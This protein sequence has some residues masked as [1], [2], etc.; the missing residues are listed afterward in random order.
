V[1]KRSTKKPPKR[2]T[3]KLAK[4][5]KKSAAAASTTEGKASVSVV[6]AWLADDDFHEDPTGESPDRIEILGPGYDGVSR[7]H[8]VDVRVYVPQI[9]VESEIEGED[10]GGGSAA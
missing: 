7:E 1:T 5:T 4:A 8:Y 9:D 3:K 10:A 2:A 6:R